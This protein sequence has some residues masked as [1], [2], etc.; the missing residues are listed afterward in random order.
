MEV[1][2]TSWKPGN[3]PE[4]SELLRTSRN[5]PEPFGAPGTFRNSSEL[6]ELVGP[7]WNSPE[8]LE[9]FRNCLEPAG[10]LQNYQEI[11]E[12]RERFGTGWNI[13][14]LPRTFKSY[15]ELSRNAG[16]IRNS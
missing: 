16:T 9:A 13:P 3:C 8:L 5:L 15:R 10:A 4:L 2:G 12:P 14:E 7:A 11:T 6:A 1:P